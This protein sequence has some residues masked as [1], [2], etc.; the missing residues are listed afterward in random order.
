MWASSVREVR[1]GFIHVDRA[2][3]FSFGGEPA[4][5]IMFL[6]QG[7]LSLDG[8]VHGRHTAFGSSPDDQPEE[9]IAIEE[10]E[11]HYVKLPTF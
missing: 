6:E 2:A 7:A 8:Q 1:V 9:I 11:L 4:R 5:E 3:S 10:S